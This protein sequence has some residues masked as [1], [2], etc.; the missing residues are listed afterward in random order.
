MRSFT[1]QVLVEHLASRP[2]RRL[3]WSVP[4]RDYRPVG[5]SCIKKAVIPKDGPAPLG[6]SGT[7]VAHRPL[8]KGFQ[9][10]GPFHFSLEGK[11]EEESFQQREEHVQRLGG[12]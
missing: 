12:Q 3:T 6:K 7:R 10:E 11:K 4:S 9:E 2:G 8:W 5:A 1:Q